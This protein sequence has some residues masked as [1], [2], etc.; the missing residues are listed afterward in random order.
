MPIYFT[1]CYNFAR[2]LAKAVGNPKAYYKDFP[3]Q[4]RE[5]IKHPEAARMF[6][7]IYSPESKV[8]NLSPG[9]IKFL[10]LFIKE[11]KFVRH[12]SDYFMRSTETFIAEKYHTYEVLGEPKLSL[13]AYAEKLKQEGTFSHLEE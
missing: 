10:S 2:H 9:L 3:I 5:G 13:T 4:G 12:M 7:E 8:S 11:M 1:H 6:L